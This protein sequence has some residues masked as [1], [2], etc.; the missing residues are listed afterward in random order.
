MS[1]VFD[2]M[3]LAEFGQR[4]SFLDEER[5]KDRELIS[6]LLERVE[7]QTGKIE[8][9]K[10]QVHE[11]EQLLASTRTELVKFTRIERSIE[12][13]RD[14]FSLLIESNE[15]KRDKAYQE[16][17][18]L[19]YIEHDAITRQIAELRKELKPIPRYDEEIQAIKSEM[20]RYDPPIIAL[21]HQL[22]DLD[23]RSEDRVQSLIF[24]EE[25]RRQDNR[26]IAEAEAE[27]LP[28]KKGI[29]NLADKLPLLEQAIQIKNK[30]IDKSAEILQRQTE[31]I[32]NQRVSEF[33]WERQVAGW[34]ELVE[35]IKRENANMATQAVRLREQD[36]VVRRALADLDSFRERIERRQDEMAE[37]QRLAEDRQRRVLEEWQT[38]REKEWERFKLDHNERWRES[39]R[40]NEKRNARVEAIEEFVRTLPA[41][42]EALWG[43]FEA[44]AQSFTIGPREWA[45]TWGELVKQRPPMPE[46][47]KRVSLAPEQLPTIRPL[48]SAQ[49]NN[50]ADEEA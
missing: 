6:T 39:A 13:L 47:L 35:E 9:Q 49:A 37:K 18:R 2:T 12:Q 8:A 20:G 32:E 7:A 1:T 33:R 19:R 5:R 28:L 34:A 40:M 25:Q 36:Q 17:T 29:D 41:L 3:E 15:E 30:E 31:V 43:V 23:K 45:V 26:R 21:Q 50:K 44:W 22:A 27:I 48:P 10:R 11:L 16:L 42:I 38:E 24:L 4:L 46:P 14:E